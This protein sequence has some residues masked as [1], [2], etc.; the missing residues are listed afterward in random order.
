MTIS[1]EAKAF[2]KSNEITL[3]LCVEVSETE[4]RDY[5][6]LT[7]SADFSLQ[8]INNVK[9]IAHPNIKVPFIQI[10][11]NDLCIQVYV[12]FPNYS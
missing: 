1:A 9:N 8:E 11:L 12:F 5:V 2:G 7:F 6:T 4:S 3:F 10:D